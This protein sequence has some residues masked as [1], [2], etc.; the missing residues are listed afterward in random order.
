MKAIVVAGVASGVGKTT[1]ATGLM[2]ALVARGLRVQGFK[3]GPDY[4]DPSYHARVT[5]RP[6]RNL[7]S[8][9]LPAPTLRALFGRAA[10]TADVAVV[11]G[12]MGLYDGRHGGGEEASTAAIAKLL[13]LPVVLVID[14]SHQARSAAA[15]VL[16]FRAFDPGVRLVGVILNRVASE[17]HR[18]TVTEAI[19][20]RAGLPVLGTLYREADL[21]LPERYLGLVPTGEGSTAAGYF[22]PGRG[23]GRRRSRSRPSAASRRGRT[24]RPGRP[25]RRFPSIPCRH[26]PAWRWRATAPSASTT[27]MP[28]ICWRRTVWRCGSSARSPMRPCRRHRRGVPGRRIPRAVRR[29]AGRRPAPPWQLRA[30]ARQ[31][32]PIYAECGGLMYLA[33]AIVDA[34]GRRHPLLGLVPAEVTLQEARLSLGYRAVVAARDTL[35]LKAGESARGHEFHYS[36]FLPGRNWT[37]AYQVA[38][39]QP[40]AEGYARGNLLASYV[41]L[42][43]A[44]QPSLARR[45]AAACAAWRAEAA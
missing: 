44:G 26:G 43:C 41:H 29:R 12:V 4:I 39:R 30:L 5:G 20:G 31:G 27:R 23:G 13:G 45:F 18:A 22:A 38:S 37:P 17:A 25:A 34:A 1:V 21:R 33:R 6:S 36:R 9:L 42:H 14:A 15:T 28:S 16:G 32:L 19:E 7:D 11:E 8:W 35:L 3:V 40:Q 2:G 10:G 24:R